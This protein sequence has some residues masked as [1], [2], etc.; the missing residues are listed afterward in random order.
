M[1]IERTLRAFLSDRSQLTRRE[2]AARDGQQVAGFD[3][4]VRP[5]SR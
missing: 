2:T 1:G 4:P 5:L 3:D